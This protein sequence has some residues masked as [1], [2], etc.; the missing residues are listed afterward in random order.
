MWLANVLC[1]SCHNA[2]YDICPGFSS[3]PEFRS[4]ASKCCGIGMNLQVGIS[5]SDTA[6]QYRLAWHYCQI[7]L[8]NMQDS[9]CCHETH[10]RSQWFP[11]VQESGWITHFFDCFDFKICM[12]P[13]A[14]SAPQI[15]TGPIIWSPLLHRAQ[16]STDDIYREIGQPGTC[17]EA[18]QLTSSHI[19]H[20]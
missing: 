18:Y 11:S 16:Y 4:F 17:N 8:A 9:I 6:T 3:A 13:H 19:H 5:Y 7:G 2:T 10:D 1:W 15:R 20:Y 14:S 12:W